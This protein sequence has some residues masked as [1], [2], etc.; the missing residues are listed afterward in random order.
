MRTPRIVFVT[1]KFPPSHG[2]METAAYELSAALASQTDT[3]I[4]AFGWGRRWAPLA[5]PLLFVRGW[6]R[7]VRRR[8]EVIVM[9]DGVLA[10][11]GVLL[12]RFTGRPVVV[13][14]HGLEITHPARLH[15]RLMRW[16]LPRVDRL[17]AV[18]ENTRVLIEEHYPGTEPMVVRNGVTDSFGSARRREEDRRL[19]ARLAGLDG[20]RLEAAMLLVTVG[21]L[22]PRKGVAWFVDQVMPL[23]R[24]GPGPDVVYLV[25]GTGAERDRIETVVAARGLGD[26]VR[27]LGEVSPD[28]L[29]SAYTAADL[30]VM[31][32]LAIPGDIEGF[33]LVAVEASSTG[34]AVVAAAA[35]GIPEAVRPSG[36]G[37]LVPPGDAAAFAQAIRAAQDAPAD[38]KRVRAFT[39]AEF[40]W[41]A[42]A[43]RLQEAAAELLAERRAAQT[44]SRRMRSSSRP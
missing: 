17:I 36:N 21:R 40:S 10:P 3:E 31:P 1:R 39:L 20:L 12:G 33:G 34:T 29:R 14:V 43:E 44:R 37:V 23:L 41:T 22:V 26:A 6:A 16:S 42:A 32:N 5:I 38:R 2:G 18:S 15:Q 4:V 7:T 27:L 13:I 28:E 9:Q 35:D 25:I 19:L 30:F 8:G 11:T 24:A